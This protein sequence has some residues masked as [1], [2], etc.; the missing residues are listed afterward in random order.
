VY[1]LLFSV[2][3]AQLLRGGLGVFVFRVCVVCVVAFGCGL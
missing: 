1:L 3:S 2:C